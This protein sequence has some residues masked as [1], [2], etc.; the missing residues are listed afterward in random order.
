[1]CNMTVRKD[2]LIKCRKTGVFPSHIVNSLKCIHP[3]LEERSPYTHKLQRI[4]DRFKKA[5]LNIEIQHTFYKIKCLKQELQ[6]IQIQLTI[7]TTND[8]ATRFI[9]TQNQSFDNRQ[10]L[11]KRRTNK[12]LAKLLEKTAPLDNSTP[13]YQD[14]TI[15]NATTVT[16]PSDTLTLLS[17]GPKFS[18]PVTSLNHVPFYHMLAD[19]EAILRVSPDQTT[20]DRNRCQIATQ[21]Q[22]YISNSKHN[23]H[24]TPLHN[25]C[26]HAATTTAKFL[27]DHQDIYILEADKGN[28]TVIMYKHE[29]D[30]KM[31]LLLNE[32]N[33]RVVSKDPTPS[34]QRQTNSLITR[35]LNLKLINSQTSI[36]LKSTTSVCPRIYGQPKAH[37]PNLPLRPVV[38]NITA[39]TYKLSKYIANILKRS[40]QSEYNISD[41]FQF[42]EYINQI[43]LPPDYVLVS[44]DV[45]SL[46]TNIPIELATHD[47]IMDWCNIK[48]YTDINLDLFLEL[49]EFCTKNSY[50]RFRDKHY[51][52]TFGTA[53]GSPLSPI[54]ADIVMENLLQTSTKLLPF[55][56]P[57]IRKYV[58]DLFL[59]LPKD[60]IA[61]TL[62]TFNAYNSNL[63]FTKEEE[64]DNKLPFLDTLVI[65]NSDQTLSTQWYAKPIASG[66]L[67]NYHS[68]HP[69][70]MKMNVAK[71]FIERVTRLTTDNTTNIQHTI[72][73][74]LRRNNYP[75]TLINRLIQRSKNT[76]HEDASN[77]APLTIRN[78]SQSISTCNHSPT[79]PPNEQIY[80]SLPHVPTLSTSIAK[81]LKPDYPNVKIATK[82]INTVSK[83]LPNTKD[84]VDPLLQSNIIYSLSCDNCTM[85]YLGMTRNQLRTRLYGHKSNI[86]QYHKLIADGT[87][88]S[89][90]QLI[91]LGEK[92][93]LIEHM[94]QHNHTFD[95]TKAK[96]IDRTYRPTALPILEMCHI[97]NTLNT[98]NHR[99][100]VDGLNTTYAGILHTLRTTNTRR[101]KASEPDT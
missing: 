5:I 48:K 83:L 6:Q 63:Q 46:F 41:S 21:I 40:Q 71:N 51:V 2:F 99:T 72:F 60:K 86:N 55:A 39:P 82:P 18:L 74:H 45:V 33:Y 32:P 16:V 10:E 44:F 92:T 91:S 36:R 73:Q 84:S 93:A 49:V 42:T 68:F 100:D 29:Y 13:K 35:L 7:F 50:F 101:N 22:N 34:V 65:R 28:R 85:S 58:D 9:T 1:M 80:R 26:K 17:L 67:L 14:K 54:L 3:L 89:N 70:S 31:T 96:I 37:K 8:I 61:L 20:Q 81:M 24:K 57:V 11:Q 53:M 47:I 98:V 43:T 97:T 23:T 56:I 4:I 19:V 78:H 25:F 76:T 87:T 59:A 69:L 66:R 88:N 79:D 95:L 77:I 94:I 30:R 27:A 15:L 75:A 52:Q 12:K 90:E 38:P 62:D 64:S